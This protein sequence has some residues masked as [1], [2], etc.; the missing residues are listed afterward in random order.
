MDFGA[1]P[2]ERGCGTREED[3]L[4]WELGMGPGGRPLID[5]LL[6]P[7][8]CIFPPWECR[9]SSGLMALCTWPTA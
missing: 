4:Y 9:Q 3:G 5:F 7:P 1:I 8:L 6:D 2:V